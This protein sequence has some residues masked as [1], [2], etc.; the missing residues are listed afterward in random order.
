MKVQIDIISEVE[1]EVVHFQVHSVEKNINRA[2]Q[3]LN[4]A[5]K[6]AGSLLCKKDETFYKIKKDDIF[7]LETMDRKVFVYT[8]KD[9]F[10]IAEKLY[11][12]EEQLYPYGFIR[13]S[14]S[15]LLNFNQIYSFYP[16]LS[17]NLEAL[18]LNQEKVIISRRYVAGLKRKLGMGENE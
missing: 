13:I 2:I 7:Y 17:G 15:M 18:L 10:E 9:T 6:D 14:K 11:V 5:E 3:I 12:L 8:E 4:S 1:E 16:K